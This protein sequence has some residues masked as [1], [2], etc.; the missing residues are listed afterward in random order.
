MHLQ[1]E[2]DPGFKPNWFTILNSTKT[3]FKNL[4]IVFLGEIT[5]K[6]YDILNNRFVLLYFY[7]LE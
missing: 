2:M 5:T 6:R 1:A 4:V 7:I 3:W